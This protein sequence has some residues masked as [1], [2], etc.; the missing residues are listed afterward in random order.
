MRL[1]RVVLTVA[2]ATPLLV[3]F[4]GGH[5]AHA[6]HCPP[7]SRMVTAAPLTFPGFGP[8]RTTQFVVQHPVSGAPCRSGFLTGNCPTGTVAADGSTITFTPNV[9]EGQ[10]CITGAVTFTVD[11]WTP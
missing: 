2:T 10:S 4:V 3:P 7:G 8:A 5:P 1:H 11:S 6:T 9:W